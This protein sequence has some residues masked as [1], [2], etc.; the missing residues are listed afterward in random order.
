MSTYK[1]INLSHWSVFI[2]CL[3]FLFLMI[4]ALLCFDSLCNSYGMYAL[5][6]LQYYAV[7]TCLIMFICY[8]EVLYI[9]E[10]HFNKHFVALRTVT[11]KLFETH[12][13]NII[14]N[15]IITLCTCFLW[16]LYA[17]HIWFI[18]YLEWKCNAILGYYL[19]R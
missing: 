19:C 7:M 8:H 10:F 6:S 12:Y 14:C 17:L 1:L 4:S 13:P 3:R 5:D 11:Y 2:F 9:L 16:N 15:T 18:F